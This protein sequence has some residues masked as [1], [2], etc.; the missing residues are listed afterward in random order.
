VID[1]EYNRVEIKTA[2]EKWLTSSRPPQDDVY[3]G[4]NAGKEI[5]EI[6]S[7]IP[8]RFHKTISY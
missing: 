4:G 7:N 6:L 3:G 1:V 8:L 2:I 5:A